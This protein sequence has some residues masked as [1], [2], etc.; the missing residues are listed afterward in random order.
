MSLRYFTADAAPYTARCIA[1]YRATGDDPVVRKTNRQNPTPAAGGIFGNKEARVISMSPEATATSSERGVPPAPLT[2]K[3]DILR[4][5]R[6]IVEEDLS[7]CQLNAG[8]ICRMLGMSR[9]TVHNRLKELTGASLTHVVNAIR[10]EHATGLLQNPDLNISEIA[11][12]VGFA[13]PAYFTRVFTKAIG[14]CP[15][16]FRNSKTEFRSIQHVV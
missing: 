4:R 6:A 13:D 5:I 3:H 16:N 7:D 9:S 10:I 11:Y 15:R 8:R 2:V 1:L 14:V 12:E